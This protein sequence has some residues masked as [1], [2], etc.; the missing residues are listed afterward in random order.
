[1][2][3]SLKD[4][5]W[6]KVVL[7]DEIIEYVIAKY[8]KNWKENEKTVDII[9]EELRIKKPTMNQRFRNV[10]DEDLSIDEDIELM[11]D[12]SFADTD[13]DDNTEGQP[14][15]V[16]TSTS[17]RYNKKISMTVCILFL[18]APNAPVDQYVKKPIKSKVKLT[19]CILALSAS[20]APDV[21]SSSIKRKSK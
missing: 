15:A 17:R 6:T 13:N 16:S 21:G 1:M 3:D 14:Q 19:N 4:K 8:E 18:R 7:T 10:S 9:L 12:V 11:G 5:D 20:N 2:V